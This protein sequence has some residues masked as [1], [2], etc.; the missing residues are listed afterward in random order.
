MRKEYRGRSSD[1]NAES[2]PYEP[3]VMGKRVVRPADCKRF[4]GGRGRDHRGRAPQLRLSR[5]TSLLPDRTW[6]R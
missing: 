2:F 5:T 6:S 3:L 1:D 4:I